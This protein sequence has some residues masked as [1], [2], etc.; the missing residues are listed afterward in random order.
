[1]QIP[2][3][4]LAHCWHTVCFAPR[5]VT[6]RAERRLGPNPTHLSIVALLFALGACGGVANRPDPGNDPV[7]NASGG[8]GSDGQSAPGSETPT[9]NGSGGS[10]ATA[11]GYPD[12][13]FGGYVTGGTGFNGSAGWGGS[14]VGGYGFGGDAGGGSIPVGGG[15]G[16]GGVAGAGS[17]PAS[18]ESPVT[19]TLADFRPRAPNDATATQLLSD[20]RSVVQGRWHGFV[21]TPWVPDYAV[22]LSFSSSNYSA[23]CDQNSDYEG[24]PGCCRAFYYGSDVDSPIKTW[25]LSSVN[26]DGTLNGLIDIAFCAAPDC[27]PA[28]QGELRNLDYD[29][30][31]NR[32]RFEF[33]RSDNYG[34]LTFELERDP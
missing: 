18:C 13:D 30:T 23:H 25:K 22:S 24:G 29:A 21:K 31:K 15:Y 1:M 20:A 11:P 19:T 14:D 27:L 3:T 9:T 12:G 26:E 5:M 4:R 16:F 7:A 28:W 34:P 33:W 8:S 32:M 17:V 6:A 10:S 2:T